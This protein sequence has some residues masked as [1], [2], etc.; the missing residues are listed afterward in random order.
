MAVDEALFLSFKEGNLLM[1]RLYGWRPAAFSVGCSQHPD[2]H[3]DPDA[4]R[5]RGLGL[6]RRPT[7]GGVLFH[8][9]ELTYSVI[10]SSS[11]INGASGVKESY[12]RIT[13]FLIEAYRS[14]G[15]AARFAKDLRDYCE[16]SH[17]SAD[18]CSA[19]K[20]PY[21]IV[22]C[23]KK[24]GGN[25]QR[26]RKNIILQHGSIPIGPP[27]S[28]LRGLLRLPAVT[29][30]F[31][32]TCVNEARGRETTFEQLSG[33]VAAAFGR[34]FA[35]APTER[36]LSPEEKNI[37]AQLET[38]KY[39]TDAWNLRRENHYPKESMAHSAA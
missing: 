29:D 31:D 10:C 36:P 26:R 35:A 20:E 25:A 39:G 6:V 5:S 2:E 17:A 11:D 4:C 27:P 13:S 16:L 12:Y 34:H 30:S 32:T 8:G 24:F 19:R 33:A 28:S 23:G 7:G 9:E 37:A 15:I 1:L 3:L 18:F 38:E 22:V 21:D 14:L